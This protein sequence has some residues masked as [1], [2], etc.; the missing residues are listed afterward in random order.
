MHLQ[1][2]M[3]HVEVQGQPPRVLGT[4]DVR[5]NKILRCLVHAKL[6]DTQQH[7]SRSFR[8]RPT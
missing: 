3:V 6:F 5:K 2:I 4:L 8:F 7:N 1:P